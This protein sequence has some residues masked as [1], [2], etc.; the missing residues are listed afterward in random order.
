MAQ[1]AIVFSSN[2]KVSSNYKPLHRLSPHF[3][4][5][6]REF[7]QAV[8]AIMDCSQKWVLSN[9]RTQWQLGKHTYN[10]LT[11]GIAEQSLAIPIVW[12]M[13]PKFG[14]SYSLAYVPKKGN[15]QTAERLDLIDK[16]GYGRR[17]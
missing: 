1:I 8:I 17:W 15:S 4:I 6:T 13:F 2:A 7:F 5:D 9:Y 14:N 12:H 10:I 16:Y 11:L 3:D